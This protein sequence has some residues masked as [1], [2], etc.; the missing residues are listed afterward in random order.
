MISAAVL[1][2]AALVLGGCSALDVVQSQ[3][4]KSFVSIQKQFPEI[5]ADSP[6]SDYVSLSSDGSTFLLVSK[7]FART[8]DGDLLISTPLKPFADAGLDVSRLTGNLRAEEDRLYLAAEFNAATAE[9][10]ALSDLIFAAIASDR[11]SF[12]Y[13]EELDHFGISLGE[14]KFEWAKDYANND[15]DIVFI[16]SADPLSSAGVDVGNVEGWIFL[17]MPDK[18][19]ADMNLLVKPSDL[20]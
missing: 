15:K 1:L 9:G 14:G 8:M 17:V 2:S 10:S 5:E 19:G 13:H 20:G 4:R 3:G 6:G 7:D 11:S 18:D 12:S 16:L